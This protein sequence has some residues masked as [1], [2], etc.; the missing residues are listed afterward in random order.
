MSTDLATVILDAVHAAGARHIFGIPGDAI[1]GLLDAARRHN[2]VD[3]VTVRHEEAGAFAAGVQAK[4]TGGLGVVAGT[5]GPGAIHLLNGLYDAKLDHAPILAITGQVET[6]QIGS[7]AHQEIDIARLFED[8][9]VF[10]ETII[11]PEQMPELVD[12][13]IR[14]AL[15]GRGVAHLVLPSDLALAPVDTSG[16]AGSAPAIG[17]PNPEPGDV[18]AAARLIDEGNAVTIL[19]GI[20]A[21]AAIPEVL[22]LAEHIGAPVI[23]T[24]RAKDLIP[25]SHPLSTGGLGLLGTTASVEAMDR[26]DVLLMV[27]TDFPYKEF[28]PEKAKTIQID[29]DPAQI[30]NRTGVDVGLVGDAG[31]ALRQLKGMVAP[32]DG[33]KHLAKATDGA[34]EWRAEMAAAESDDSAPIRPQRL[35]ATLSRHTKPGTI[36]VC[37]TGTV[38]V[39]AA[40]HLDIKHGDRFTLSAN[41]ASMAIALPGAIGAQLAYPES[42]VVA[43]AGDGGFSMLIGD[44]ITAVD[45][46]LP[47]TVVVFNNSK[48]GLIGVEQEAEGLPAF[49]IELQNPNFAEVARAM[50]AEGWRVEDPADLDGAIA[51]ALASNRPSVVDVVVNPDEVT[52]PPTIE[53][54]FALGYTK[55]K[56]REFASGSEAMDGVKSAVRQTI[57]R[58]TN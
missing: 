22:A 44:L 13:A 37:D 51:A 3:F 1:N 31:A 58:I 55:A 12:K 32:S 11:N 39:W 7:E 34:A 53:L 49:G 52:M 38:T 42:P 33:G 18:E 45:L 27:G 54:K 25:D 26:T 29:I 56:V 46:E 15:R 9:A 17:F 14:E 24:L 30:G 2:G 5:A 28:Y 50:G 40:R 21:R 16:H 19:V 35:A 23:R 47:I 6:S 43:L 4:L 20:G 41:L 8:V 48:L 57:E 10:S 36:F